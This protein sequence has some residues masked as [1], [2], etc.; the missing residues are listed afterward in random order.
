MNIY[1][2]DADGDNVKQLTKGDDRSRGPAWSPDG[3]K[4][5]FSRGAANNTG[6]ALFMM[7]ADGGESQASRRRRRLEPRVVARRQ[8]D[9]VRVAA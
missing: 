9:L 5:I 4:I 8:K 7:D 6:S 2:M 3:K 1:V